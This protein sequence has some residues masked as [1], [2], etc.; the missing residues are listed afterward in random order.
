MSND[1]QDNQCNSD[2]LLTQKHPTEDREWNE[3][4]ILSK[5]PKVQKKIERRIQRNRT[6]QEILD[7]TEAVTRNIQ[8]ENT[9]ETKRGLP[10]FKFTKPSTLYTDAI[11]DGIQLE[12]DK[13]DLIRP[14]KDT[15]TLSLSEIKKIDK[16]L[17]EEDW[18]QVYLAFAKSGEP[19]KIAKQTKLPIHSVK[20]LLHKGIEHINLPP[21]L[22]QAVDY[23]EVQ[24]TI[25]KQ[26]NRRANEIINRQ[27]PKVAQVIQERVTQDA[28]ASQRLLEQ[29]VE[30][31]ELIS[32]FVKT[33]NQNIQEGTASLAIPE[34]ITPQVL[35]TLSKVLDAHSRTMERAIKMTRLTAGESTDIIEHQTVALLASLTTSELI[36]AER[37]GKLPKRL[38]ARISGS[39]PLDISNKDNLSNADNNKDKE[40][41]VIEAD[42]SSFAD[43]ISYLGKLEDE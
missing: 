28:A 5:D 10:E 35:E 4:K 31:G 8:I 20:H 30:G 33:L 38:T 36:E 16:T 41:H 39:D 9:K 7:K 13:L 29:A 6:S 23:E 12:K 37:T 19:Y 26:R 1:S 2:N 24:R 14:P 15:S 43:E 22:E 17:K 34:F 42:Y 11:Q 3:V 27:D 32:Q 40:S 21:I 18:E 25:A